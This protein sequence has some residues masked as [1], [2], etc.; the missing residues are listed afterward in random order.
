MDATATRS[1]TAYA[2]RSSSMIK[3]TARTRPARR[4]WRRRCRPSQGGLRPRA[5][6]AHPLQRMRTA[7]GSARETAPHRCT[8]N[9]LAQDILLF[10]ASWRRS[11]AGMG[12]ARGQQIAS[13]VRSRRALGS[14]ARTMP[15]SSS[16]SRVPRP[17]PRMRRARRGGLGGG[18]A[19]IRSVGNRRA[20][21]RWVRSGSGSVRAGAAATR[22]RASVRCRRSPARSRA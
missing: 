4:T 5:S 20:G 6:E 9:F 17:T 12:A 11:C 1:F 7:R 13:A 19:P 22:R 8:A 15:A 18:S 21:S 3:A 14:A 16:C 2:S 10:R